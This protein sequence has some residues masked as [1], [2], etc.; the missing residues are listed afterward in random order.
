MRRTIVP[1]KQGEPEDFEL[2]GNRAWIGIRNVDLRLAVD[3]N[4]LT[5]E[6]F[7]RG[8]GELEPVDVYYVDFDD[9]AKE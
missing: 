3:D 5:I 4:G 2:V 8:G 1:S 9:Y 7:E 6:A